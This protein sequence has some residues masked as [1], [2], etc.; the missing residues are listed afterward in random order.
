MVVRNHHPKLAQALVD[1][2]VQDVLGA[3]DISPGEQRTSTT[4]P[5]SLAPPIVGRHLAGDD[6]DNNVVVVRDGQVPQ[7][8]RA[9]QRVCAL[10][11]KPGQ[12]SGS[13]G[14]S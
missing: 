5:S 10:K 13:G 6:A 14:V 8:H 4:H 7:A 2:V 3:G 1:G 11:R 9:E 12:P